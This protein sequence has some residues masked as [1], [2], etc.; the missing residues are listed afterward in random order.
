VAFRIYG[1]GVIQSSTRA[2]KM[3]LELLVCC[4]SIRRLVWAVATSTLPAVS[5]DV[6]IRCLGRRLHVVRWV[7]ERPAAARET[8]VGVHVLLQEPAGGYLYLG[9]DSRCAT[10]IAGKLFTCFFL[11]AMC[12]VTK[13]L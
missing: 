1:D 13:V 8:T 11:L 9:Y 3:R 6:C 7:W 5:S 10:P 12:I 2:R 4:H